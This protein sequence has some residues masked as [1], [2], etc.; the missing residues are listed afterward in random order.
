MLYNK[1]LSVRDQLVDAQTKIVC[2]PNGLDF[3]ANAMGLECQGG[4]PDYRALIV[5][6]EAQLCEIDNLLAATEK[7]SGA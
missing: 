2:Q 5:E 4:P 6:L 7:E 3:R 1:E